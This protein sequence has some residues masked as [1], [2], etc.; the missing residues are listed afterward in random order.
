MLCKTPVGLSAHA[1]SGATLR[2]VHRLNSP[3]AAVCAVSVYHRAA[4]AAL[5]ETRQQRCS[6]EGHWPTA[7]P[8]TSL[9]SALIS[10]ASSDLVSK[11]ICSVGQH[12]QMHK[13][14][15]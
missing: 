8:P 6:H 10:L 5:I 11:P 4:N 14:T 3:V 2:G 9:Q 7:R 13:C 12:D 15:F 1:G